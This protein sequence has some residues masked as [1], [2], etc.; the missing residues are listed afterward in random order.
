MKKFLKWIGIVI[1][2]LVALLLI[3][4]FFLVSKGK[5]KIAETYEVKA[6]LLSSV[7]SDSASLAEGERLSQIHA[8]KACHGSDLSGSE[9]VDAPPFLVVTANLTSGQGGIGSYYSVQDYDRAI[10]HGVRP[11]G[12]SILLMPSSTL[13]NLTDEDA[14]RLIGYLKSISSVDNE[15]P[16]TKMR[17]LGNLLVGLGEFDPA[18]QVVT[19]TKRTAYGNS[20]VEQGEYLSGMTCSSCHGSDLRGGKAL[21]PGMLDP[22]NLATAGA[23]P[24]E[25]FKR[26]LSEGL[27][28]DN[29]AIKTSHMPWDGYKYMTEEE[30]R[31]IYTYLKT[32]G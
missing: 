5:T 24:F 2:S 6:N 10:R 12:T 13:H 9:M 8:C 23:L 15:L 1:V 14:G 32:L 27:T 21:E 3:V 17:I 28:S 31:A 30:M 22:P 4:G 19:G 7:P 29:R 25:N 16:K 26:V 11:N 18:E 20:D